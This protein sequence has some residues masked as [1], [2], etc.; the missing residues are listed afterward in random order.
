MARVDRISHRGHPEKP[1]SPLTIS[2]VFAGPSGQ[3]AI[4]SI[5]FD[6]RVAPRCIVAAV[7]TMVILPDAHDA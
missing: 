1:P 7:T 2:L 6:A 4:T 3:V 5:A